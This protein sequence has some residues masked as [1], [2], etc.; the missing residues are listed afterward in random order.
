[1]RTASATVLPSPTLKF[2]LYSKGYYLLSKDSPLYYLQKICRGTVIQRRLDNVA[3][4]P[5]DLATPI[6]LGLVPHKVTRLTNQI[7]KDLLVSGFEA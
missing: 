2:G 3:M 5:C 7:Q 1:M 6:A 4:H